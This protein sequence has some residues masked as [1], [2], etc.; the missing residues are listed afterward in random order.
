MSDRFGIIL[1]STYQCAICSVCCSCH[2]PAPSAFLGARTSSGFPLQEASRSPFH[3]RRFVL[4]A[5]YIET[6]AGAARSRLPAA[7]PSYQLAGGSRIHECG[8]RTS[9]ACRGDARAL[10]RTNNGISK[11]SP[12]TPSSCNDDGRWRRRPRP[13]ETSGGRIEP[14]NSSDGPSLMI[15]AFE[16]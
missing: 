8:S 15:T 13:L 10:A 16:L 9:T 12:A 2:D 5:G 3:F 7:S 1:F 11:L 6:L 14:Y 4:H